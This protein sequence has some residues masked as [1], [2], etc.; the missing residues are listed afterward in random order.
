MTGPKSFCGFSEDDIRKFLE[1][2]KNSDKQ[3]P[4]NNTDAQPQGNK[5][6]LYNGILFEAKPKERL[7]TYNESLERLH[8]EGYERHARH[9]EA[10]GLLI[11]G[12]EG[13]LNK[14]NYYVYESIGKGW[15]WISLALERKDDKIIAYVDPEGLILD[16]EGYRKDG[17]KFKYS[18]RNAFRIECDTKMS[19]LLLSTMEDSFVEFLYTKRL[20]DLPNKLQ[21]GIIPVPNN[22]AISPVILRFFNFSLNSKRSVSRGVRK[23]GG[24]Q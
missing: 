2:Q 8:K 10:F 18:T 24:S 7:F 1:E 11:D 19:Y 14:D 22:H 15:E 20:I 12:L 6:I 4:A 17:H 5:D 9:Q 16:D 21:S 23:A 13:R 3:V